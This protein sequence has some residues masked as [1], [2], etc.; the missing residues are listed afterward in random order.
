MQAKM[1]AAAEA[2]RAAAEQVGEKRGEQAFQQYRFSVT[3]HTPA[4]R[5]GLPMEVAE[6]RHQ[7]V[8]RNGKP[9][10]H[11]FGYFTR[12]GRLYP[13]WDD[14]GPYDEFT[15]K[16][17]GAVTLASNPN[18]NF[19]N[20]HTGTA[21]ARSKPRTRDASLFLKE[22]DLGGWHDAYLNPERNDVHDLV[23]AI[24]DGD[25]EEMSFA[26]LIPDGMGM[27]SD[28]FST[29]EIRQWDIN[30]GD[31]SAVNNGANPYTDIT[32]DTAGVFRALERLPRGARREA[33]ARLS[34][35]T[36]IDLSSR[37]VGIQAVGR[38]VHEVNPKASLPTRR[39]QWEVVHTQNRMMAHVDQHDLRIQDLPAVRLPWY[40]MREAAQP[41]A[42]GRSATDVL[43]YN[44][45]GGSFGVSAETFAAELADVDTDIIN[46]RINSPGGSVQ[47]ALAIH[48]TLLHHP[49]YVHTFI[50]GW[51][52]SA[53]TVVALAGDRITVMP[54][55]EMMIHDASQPA[56]PNP[57][58]AE[59]LAKQ[60]HRQ[61]DNIAGMYAAR[62]GG[63]VE[64]FRALMSAE[65]WLFAQ[66]AVD[67]GLAD[68][69]WTRDVPAREE[70]MT[71]SWDLRHFRYAGRRSA[72]A[73]QK[74]GYA[75]ERP[76][77]RPFLDVV[78]D[79]VSTA[80]TDPETGPAEVIE[81]SS[82]TEDRPQGR[83]IAYIE[84]L[85]AAEGAPRDN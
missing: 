47:D 8:T 62:A 78:A 9:A 13:M 80:L 6:L 63:T 65:T 51:A 22:D 38:S 42:D 72:P 32:A 31:V 79:A 85:L 1:R 29:F 69:V 44:S 49:A 57:A 34:D 15:A 21:M 43:I 20:N 67:L 19:L 53:A 61:S 39:M 33:M 28:D 66:E 23:T 7:T 30:G 17:S 5:I 25:V 35:T 12:Y 37:S 82:T 55:G 60:L 41:A 36:F 68:D 83:S 26:F 71:R 48:S 64:E 81:A 14:F 24:D 11:T 16:G 54:G 3:G 10:V 56:N 45:I 77:V 75:A 4:R 2:R 73:P 52:C 46:L 59:T 18:V 58:E 74:R 50:D 70:R 40:E 27:W 84:A 76:E